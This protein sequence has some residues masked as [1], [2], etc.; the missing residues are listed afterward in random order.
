MPLLTLQLARVPNVLGIYGASGDVFPARAALLHP[1]AA[2]GFRALEARLGQRVRVSDVFRTAEES[3]KARAS[4]AGVQPPG[5]SL[6]NYGIAIDIATDAMIKATG[7]P[8]PVLDT[9]FRAAGWY[10]HRKDGAR[11]VE[12]W[13]FNFLGVGAAAEPF[14]AA[15]AKSTVTSAAGDAKILA[16]YGDG[17][18]LT[19][20]ETQEALASLRMYGG[21]V[22]GILGPRSREAIKVFQRAW[23]LEETGTVDARTERTL[24][25]VTAKLEIVDG[26]PR[27]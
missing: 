3:L 20:H 15:S 22:D 21:E 9:V 27:V 24:A 7:M 12:D 13:H 16:L 1:E 17:L 18:K 10:C 26:A 14:L 19:P 8:K 11:G 2:A 6:H 23:A 5:F 4:K 25:Y